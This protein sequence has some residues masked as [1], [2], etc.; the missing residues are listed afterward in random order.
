[1]TEEDPPLGDTPFRV[2]VEES[3]D[4]HTFSPRDIVAVVEDYLEAAAS[5]G[6]REVRL[7]HGKGTGVQRAAVRGVLSRHP[8]VAAFNDAP[9]EAGGWGATR[10]I[11]RSPR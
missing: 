1:M 4:L 9:P 6:Y 5:K 7:I 10:V 8:L 3:I 11:L 2:P